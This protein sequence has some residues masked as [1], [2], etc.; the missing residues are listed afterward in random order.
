MVTEK[1]NTA[2]QNEGREIIANTVEKC[3]KE[4]TQKLLLLPLLKATK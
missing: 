1:T 3:D 2:I 4:K